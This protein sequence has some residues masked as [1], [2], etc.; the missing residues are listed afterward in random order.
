MGLL[1]IVYWRSIMMEDQSKN[2]LIDKWDNDKVH[3]SSGN[4]SY[5]CDCDETILYCLMEFIGNKHKWG[6]FKNAN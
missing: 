1:F 4:K 5:L 6:E 3:V 2:I